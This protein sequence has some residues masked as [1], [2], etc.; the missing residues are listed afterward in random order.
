MTE[1]HALCC[2]EPLHTDS[3]FEA[4]LRRIDEH[5]E[6]ARVEDYETASLPLHLVL[7]SDPP[8]VVVK[9]L[10][11]AYPEALREENDHG[12]LPLH[13]ACRYGAAPNV[14]QYLIDQYPEAVA[15]PTRTQTGLQVCQNLL[16]DPY[17]SLHYLV[18][19]GKG[20]SCHN[21]ISKL[22]DDHPHRA[23]LL[24]LLGSSRPTIY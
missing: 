10:A 15:R 17:E 7:K 12:L 24:E 23:G 2:A 6:E 16:R 20:L 9:A 19:G 1:L 14:A 11:E 18:T 22:P 3:H 13:V 5:P 8:L 21:L 4:I